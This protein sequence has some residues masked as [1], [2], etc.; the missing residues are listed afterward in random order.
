M[1]SQSNETFYGEFSDFDGDLPK[2]IIWKFIE[3]SPNETEHWVWSNRNDVEMRGDKKE[4]TK[5]IL[6]WLYAILGNVALSWVDYSE[7]MGGPGYRNI[8]PIVTEEQFQIRTMTLDEWNKFCLLWDDNFPKCVVASPFHIDYIISDIR[9]EIPK[10][11][12]F[13]RMFHSETSEFN[14][15]DNCRVLDSYVRTAKRV[16]ESQK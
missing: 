6:D 9:D 1:V 8:K 4:I 16:K 5:N 14:P 2:E 3:P 11:E 7:E 10:L 12:D 13:R 15:I